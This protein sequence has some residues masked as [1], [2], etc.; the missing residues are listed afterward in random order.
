MKISSF[1]LKVGIIVF[2]GVTFIVAGLMFGYGLLIWYYPQEEP[3]PIDP[4]LTYKTLVVY[5]GQRGIKIKD[6]KWGL[7]WEPER[8]IYDFFNRTDLLGWS[9]NPTRETR[10]TIS[11]TSNHEKTKA[12]RYLREGIAAG[13]VYVDEKNYLVTE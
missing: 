1:L 10:F 13:E 11:V 3:E 9:S 12:L 8:L 6:K 5:E 2:G 7:E 4:S